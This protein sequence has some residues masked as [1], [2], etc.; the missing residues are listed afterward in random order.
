MGY[1]LL[2][3]YF[4]VPELFIEMN[5]LGKEIDNLVEICLALL[6]HIHLEDRKVEVTLLTGV[7]DLFPYCFVTIVLHV[8]R[9]VV[10]SGLRL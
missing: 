7:A 8:G 3:S 10:V 4:G 2:P 6:D 1:V 5:V 9:T